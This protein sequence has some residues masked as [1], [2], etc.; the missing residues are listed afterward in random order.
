[1]PV[2][3]A[4]C[5]AAAA[6]AAVATVPG[7]TSSLSVSPSTLD[8]SGSTPPSAGSSVV[9]GS[10]NFPE[11]ELLAEI[12][13]QA[14]RGAGVKVTTKLNIGSR[15]AYYPQVKSGAISIIPEYNGAL[16]TTSV[17]TSSTAVTTAQV[18]AALAADLPSTMEVLRPSSATDS[19]SVTVTRATA[20]K[21]HLTTIADLTPHAKDM[22][23]GGPQEIK[24]RVDGLIGLK[25][26]YGLTFK[27]F[28]PLDE[29]GPI[30]LAALAS[31][32]VQAADVFTTTPQI[33]SDHLVVLSDSKNN[34]AAQNVIPLVYRKA[35]TPTI[36]ATLNAV[37]AKL[38]T[39]SLLQL[40]NAVIT[41]DAPLSVVAAAFL[42]AE[43]L[44]PRGIDRFA[45]LHRA[46]WNC[47][48]YE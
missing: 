18:D 15:E 20:A 19:D 48:E 32:K 35:M 11:D 13:A 31:G 45:M 3:L 23:L 40:D 25:K 28:V 10:A 26:N 7:C 2:K 37:D 14:L 39:A 1:M 36:M 34:F 21:Y 16:L 33:I 8:G 27:S 47:Y 22:A 42:K 12:Y 41:E 38:T 44:L 9:V 30:T 5:V 6:L 17:N 4:Y 43:G 29:S 24:T 46:V